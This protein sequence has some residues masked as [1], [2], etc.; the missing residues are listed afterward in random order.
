MVSL[1][2]ASSV[3]QGHSL[4]LARVAARSRWE[5]WDLNIRVIF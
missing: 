5:P 4:T 3:F 1:A 2:T